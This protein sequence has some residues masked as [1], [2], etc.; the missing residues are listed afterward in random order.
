MIKHSLEEEELFKLK[1]MSLV[2]QNNLQ[3]NNNANIINQEI[4]SEIQE[5]QLLEKNA[6]KIDIIF[7]EFDRVCNFRKY[8]PQFNIEEI[9]KNQPKTKMK[10]KEIHRKYK[11]NNIY[12]N[13]KYYSFFVNPWLERIYN[14]A[15]R[16]KQKFLKQKTKGKSIKLEKN[17]I[18]FSSGEN[19][20]PY[21]KNKTPF[22]VR[23]EKK[24]NAITSF[25][26]L[27]TNLIKNKNNGESVLVKNKSI[28]RQKS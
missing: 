12:K 6:L 13:Y 8:F 14:E 3:T 15:E 4:A 22:F 11:A 7:Q 26:D 5:Q 10:M 1:K 17:S 25:G 21:I 24:E 27:I 28:E 2:K 23:N 16:R 18:F 20:S 19:L 9:I